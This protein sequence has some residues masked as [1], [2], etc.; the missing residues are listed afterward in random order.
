MTFISSHGTIAKCVILSRVRTI[1][2]YEWYRCYMDKESLV[3]RSRSQNDAVY[4]CTSMVILLCG[5]VGKEVSMVWNY[6]TE[7]YFRF[8]N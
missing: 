6:E 2:K 8:L 3:I 4:G 7:V 5:S 1:E